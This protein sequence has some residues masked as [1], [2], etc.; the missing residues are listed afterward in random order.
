MKISI[1]IPAFNNLNFTINC[2]T[3]IL[4]ENKYLNTEI[5]VIDNGSKDKTSDIIQ[6]LYPKIKIIKNI[7]NLGF[8]KAC[9]QG[10]ESSSGDLLI[11][12]NNDTEVTNGWIEKLLECIK[13]LINVGIVG[14]KL[15]YPNHKVQH[16]GVSFSKYNVHHIYRNFPPNHPAVNKYRQFQAVTAACMLVSRNLFI[17]L[18]GFDESF[19]NG[20]EDLDFCFRV[21]S[22]G[23]K[24]MYNP[25]SV[26]IHHESKSLGRHDNHKHNASY[27]SSRWASSVVQDLDSL[28]AED[29]MRRLVAYEKKFGGVW[30]EDSNPNPSWTEAKSLA[31][32]GLH[33]EA[34]ATYRVALDFNPHD[35]RRLAITE[36]LGDLYMAMD[37]SIDA[38]ACYDS[39]L[40]IHASDYLRNKRA[41]IK[42]S[43]PYTQRS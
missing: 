9:N 17:H 40:K 22:H 21:R 23:L 29:G 7:K 12:L 10:A 33:L 42:Q 14:C 38:A 20:F 27:F 11:F 24:V 28:Y 1:I 16:A 4:T 2:I 25:D 39:I 19:I 35:I 41:R 37:R 8:A 31:A 5:I 43:S 6:N 26:V 30:L 36:E 15:L 34:E 13:R 18:G 3:S 32:S